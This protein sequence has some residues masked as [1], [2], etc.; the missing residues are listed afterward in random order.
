[1]SSRARTAQTVFKLSRIKEVQQKGPYANTF[2]PAQLPKG[3]RLKY[4][5]PTN[6][7]YLGEK[8][9]TP[10]KEEQLKNR[11]DTEIQTKNLLEP[12]SGES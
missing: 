8:S 9:R 12:Q 3:R 10:L 7:G 6:C 4:K 5:L 11:K 2:S 1:M